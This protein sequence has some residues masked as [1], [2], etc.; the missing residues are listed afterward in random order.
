MSLTDNTGNP[1]RERGTTQETDKTGNPK[2]KRGTDQETDKT[3]NPKRKRGTD[4]CDDCQ[5]S[6]SLTRR[7]TKSIVRRRREG[8]NKTNPHRINEVVRRGGA[9][10]IAPDAQ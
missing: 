10:F 2:R 5:H 1:K 6:P 8:I 9:G 7:V 4:L 3:G